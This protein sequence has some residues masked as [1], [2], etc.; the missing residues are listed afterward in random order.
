MVRNLVGA[1]VTVGTGE[2]PPAALEEIL[3]L[4]NRARN[5]IPPAAPH[6]LCLLRVDY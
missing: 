5:P 1:L 6:G 4:R 3:A 2:M